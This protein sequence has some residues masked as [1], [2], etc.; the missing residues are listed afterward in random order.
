MFENERGAWLVNGRAF[1]LD[2]VD[3][4]VKRNS[5]EIWVLWNGG[6]D[7]TH[8]IGLRSEGQG[9][10]EL[11]P[12]RELRV[13]MRFGDWTGRYVLHCANFVHEDLGMMIRWDVEP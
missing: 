5:S 11:A 3:A 10:L 9:V 13:L 8:P 4:R 2:R 6:R 1:D 7:S 12:G